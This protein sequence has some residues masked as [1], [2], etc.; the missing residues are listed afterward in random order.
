MSIGHFTSTPTSLTCGVPQGSILGPLL[1]NLY[2][3]PL[4]QIIKNHSICYHNY[5]DDTQIYL[6]LSPNEFAPLESLYKC[7]SHVVKSKGRRPPTHRI[8][9][10]SLYLFSLGLSMKQMARHCLISRVEKTRQLLSLWRPLVFCCF[11]PA[12]TLE[13]VREA[14]PP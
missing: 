2:M 8:A 6:S 4:G 7:L 5:A 1:F 10:N 13:N 9:F 11:L 3:L 14:W 12:S